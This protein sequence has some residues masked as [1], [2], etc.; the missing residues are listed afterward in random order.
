MHAFE[1]PIS[2]R[3]RAS[4][5]SRHPRTDHLHDLGLTS[6]GRAVRAHVYGPTAQGRVSTS[7]PV[8]VTTRVCSN[9]AVHD[10]S[11][12]VTVQ[13]SSQM[14]QSMPPMV[15][16]GSMVNVMPFSIRVVTLGSS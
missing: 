15:I 8:S 13:L 2:P 12:V 9:C 5:R 10:L 16:I 11:L 1:G 4:P 7:A 6:A 14:S 3:Q